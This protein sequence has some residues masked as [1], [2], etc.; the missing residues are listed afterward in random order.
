MKI[1][2]NSDTATKTCKITVHGRKSDIK[3]VVEEFDSFLG[4]LQ[5]CAVIRHPNGGL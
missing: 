3:K 5:H 4:W 2:V 1:I